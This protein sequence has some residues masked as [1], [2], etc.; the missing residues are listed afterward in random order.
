MPPAPP[1]MLTPE[2]RPC[3]PA[4]TAETQK[5]AKPNQRNA[6]EAWASVQRL[7]VSREP[8]VIELLWVYDCEG[9]QKLIIVNETIGTYAVATAVNTKVGGHGD[10]TAEVEDGVQDIKANNE[11]R[12]DHE[13]LLDACGNEVQQRKHAEDRDKHAVV[14]NRRVARVGG[15]DHVTDERHDEEGP[16]ELH[17]MLGLARVEMG[18]CCWLTWRPRMA[19]L[20]IFAT[21]LNKAEMEYSSR[22][23]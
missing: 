18:Q 19:R 17:G 7:L 5:A 15:C 10:S 20:M 1:R 16:D 22:C 2:L 13:R 21:I 8:L 6:V 9:C 3:R 12:V 14:D 4:K 23:E 11:E